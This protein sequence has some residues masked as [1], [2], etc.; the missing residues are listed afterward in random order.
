MIGKHIRGFQHL[1]NASDVKIPKKII[2]FGWRR[3]TSREGLVLKTSDI[4]NKCVLFFNNRY[5]GDYVPSFVT[6]EEERN[7]CAKILDE[8]YS[9]CLVIES[10]YLLNDIGGEVIMVPDDFDEEYEKFINGNK[11]MLGHIFTNFCQKDNLYA[12]YMYIMTEGSPNLFAWGMKNIFKLNV[13]REL[14]VNCIKWC[15]NYP[16]LTKNLSKGTPTAYSG[17]EQLVS[18]YYE[19]VDL[20]RKKRANDVINMFN[21]AQKKALKGIEINETISN[22]FSKFSLLSFTKQHNFIRKM[23]TIEDVDEIMRQMSLLTKEHFEWN[24]ESLMKFIKNVEGINCNIVYD[25]DNIVIIKVDDYDTIK[26]LAKTTNW[27]IS[28]NKKYWNDYITSKG[29]KASQYVMFDFSKKED[30]DLSIVGFTTMNK[31]GITHA[32]SFTNENMMRCNSMSKKVK[33]FIKYKPS[34]FDLLVENKVPKLNFFE[35]TSLKYDWNAESFCSF[36]DNTLCGSD[37]DIIYNDG[38][39]IVIIAYGESTKY[40]IGENVYS[41]VYGSESEKCVIFLDFTKEES[42]YT[43]LMFSFILYNKRQQEE[44]ASKLF[45]LNVNVPISISFEEMLSRFDLPYNVICRVE[46]K[47]ERLTT[48]YMNCDTQV[49]NQMLS[50]ESF[51]SQLKKGK[52]RNHQRTL[53]SAISSS[54]FD[55]ATLDLINVTYA[56]GLTLCELMGEAEMD[57]LFGNIVYEIVCNRMQDYPFPTEEEFA[58]LFEYKYNVNKQIFIGRCLAFKTIVENEKTDAFLGDYT[59]SVLNGTSDVKS[60]FDDVLDILFPFILKS[61]RLLKMAIATIEHRGRMD[62]IEKILEVTDSKEV[63]NFL[64]RK[65]PRSNKLFAV[66]EAKMEHSLSSSKK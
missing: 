42:D 47:I 3:G 4:N 44:F 23:S 22:M 15:L 41:Q 9:C 43:R 54:I 66:V 5:G 13:P 38:D 50:D 17:V 6:D 19:M 55:N 20:R 25:K 52:Y 64:Y 7:I 58:T 48:A 34:I 28:K 63:I 1:Y 56:N 60:I 24:K 12:L 29:K 53:C 18:L 59:I 65:L 21:T 30:D 16:R 11:K 62:L 26:Y 27:C 61:K 32:H 10:Q 51:V 39:K 46:D 37:Y 33:S 2:I 40:I 49:I 35:K 45:S 57:R 31:K 8:K 36:V 14:I